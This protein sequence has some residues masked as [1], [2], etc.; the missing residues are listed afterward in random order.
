MGNRSTS[1][2]TEKDRKILILSFED[3]YQ[4]DICK[5][6]CE[7]TEKFPKNTGFINKKMEFQDSQLT[8]WV[9]RIFI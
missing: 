9:G 6:L 1:W 2:Y 8:L 3:K 7:T 5:S 4:L